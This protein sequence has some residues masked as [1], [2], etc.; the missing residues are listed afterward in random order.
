MHLGHAYSALLNLKM[1]RESNGVMLLRIEDI[2]TARCTPENE[3]LMLEDLE[4]VGF[5][6]DEKPIRQSSQFG[7]YSA[8]IS[9]LF[10]EGIVYPTSM[11]RREIAE[12][13]E[14]MTAAGKSWQTDPDGA[15]LYPGNERNMDA[16]ERMSILTGGDE[17]A[18]RLDMEYAVSTVTGVLQWHESGAGPDGQSGTISADP[19]TWGDAVLGRKDVPA[20]YHLSAVLDDAL[21]AIT[22]IVRGRDLFYATA[23]HRLLQELLQLPVPEYHHHDLV[24][25]EDGHKLSKSRRSTALRHLR[26]AG[27]TPFDVRRMIGLD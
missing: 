24:L 7:R 14:A 20:S 15:P 17:Y 16:N 5:E 27:M 19:L 4:W 12:A 23:V 3:K 9:D 6:W 21:Q 8:T 2:D 26:E 1:A 13:V 22:H 18:M 11:S 10:D 25:D